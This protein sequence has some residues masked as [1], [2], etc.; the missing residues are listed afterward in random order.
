VEIIE[1]GRGVGDAVGGATGSGDAQL[2]IRH[3]GT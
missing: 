2:R 3:D 1:H